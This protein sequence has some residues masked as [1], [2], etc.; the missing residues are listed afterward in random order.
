MAVTPEKIRIRLARI[1][2]RMPVVPEITDDPET[3]VVAK[4]VTAQ[5]AALEAEIAD[6]E[7]QLTQ[8]EG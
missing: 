6:L 4:R 5:I 2:S 7:L 3:A 1:R 8:L